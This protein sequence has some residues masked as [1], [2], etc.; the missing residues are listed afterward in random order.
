M[1]FAA[2]P[3]A[4]PGRG[5][6][7]EGASAKQSPKLATSTPINLS[8][9]DMSTKLKLMGVDVASFGDCFADAPSPPAPLPGGAR[10]EAANAITYPD[11]LTGSYKKLGRKSV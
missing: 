4:P 2:S 3:L 9:A 11:P 5:A 7:G 8:F 10:G 6:G 1:A